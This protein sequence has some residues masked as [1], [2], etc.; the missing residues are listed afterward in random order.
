MRRRRANAS[1]A[2]RFAIPVGIV[3]ATALL[4]AYLINSRPQARP[5][6][7]SERARPVKLIPALYERA[8]SE[9]LIY[10][11][12]VAGREAELR[13]M[14][15][16]RLVQVAPILREGAYVAA[17][18]L[19]AIVDP[20][21][22]EIAV[23]EQG[24]NLDEARAVR[25]ELESELANQRQLLSL[26]D[27]QIALRTRDRERAARLVAR[28]QTSEK[29]VDDAEL[30]LNAAR[31]QRR[32]GKQQIDKLNARI[33]QQ[34]A[35]I[36]R[37]KATLERVERDLADTEVS[38]PFR[39]F[40]ADVAVGLG[41]RVAVG[42]SIGRLID[43]DALEVRF[44]LPNDDYARLIAAHGDAEVAEQPLAGIGVEVIW[45]LGKQAY[46]YRAVLAH[47]GAEIDPTTGGVGL[48]ATILDGPMALLR[49][50]AFVDVR[51][52]GVT[53]D[54]VLV[55]PHT[56]VSRANEV[57]SVVDSRLVVHQ[58]DVVE[59]VGDKIYVKTDIPPHREIVAEQFSDIGPG[60]LVKPL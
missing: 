19:L 50:G 45:R 2:T 11:E 49:P 1:F 10:G 39:G 30:A 43:A 12:V 33:A 7:V 18:T 38:A 25:R 53:Y 48:I 31:Q 54:D 4:F 15:A 22:Y 42:E 8:Q 6:P 60:V 3:V 23:R 41:K 58:V 14:V 56:A 44:E 17:N 32:Q 21:E 20:F 24:A 51:L 29:A 47:G 59:E 9:L 57:Y 26:V 36:E 46:N 28:G 34:D 52:A 16:G 55:L 5:N 13:A 37:H 40:L 35:T 27:E